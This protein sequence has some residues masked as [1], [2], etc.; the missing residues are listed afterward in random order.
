[1]ERKPQERPMEANERKDYFYEKRFGYYLNQLGRA[2]DF[3]GLSDDIKAVLHESIDEVPSQE[4]FEVTGRLY[5]KYFNSFLNAGR[6]IGQDSLAEGRI[7]REICLQ[8]IERVNNP[9]EYSKLK[10][11]YEMWSEKS[12]D[13]LRKQYKDRFF[14]FREYDDE[15]VLGQVVESL[16]QK[17]LPLPDNAIETE[18][19]VWSEAVSPSISRELF[20]EDDREKY[21]KLEETIWKCALDLGEIDENNIAEVER[22]YESISGP[23]SNEIF[24]R[25][26]ITF[27]EDKLKA[28]Y[29]VKDI[30]RVLAIKDDL[31]ALIEM[32]E[33]EKEKEDTRSLV[34]RTM[35]ESSINDIAM[36]YI[37]QTD[38]IENIRKFL[39]EL[40]VLSYYDD[41]SEA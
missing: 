7:Y 25:E 39:K 2:S 27:V 6:N 28:Y 11:N 37:R 38:N 31:D 40:P 32:H 9:A 41:E 22:V 8:K 29:F 30:D 33:V 13:S 5:K 17:D 19:E 16:Q 20:D 36:K 12:R 1:M 35:I 10:K 34:L 24:S 4:F 21:Q 26:L 3:D 14:D 15:H 18:D 23:S